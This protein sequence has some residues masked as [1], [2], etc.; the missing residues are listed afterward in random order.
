LLPR[1]RPPPHEILAENRDGLP[2]DR[3]LDL[4]STTRLP[5][6]V[7]GGEV[8]STEDAAAFLDEHGVEPTRRPG[9]PG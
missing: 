9:A 7:V 3:A 5:A 6:A 8:A 1:P 2:P 4:R